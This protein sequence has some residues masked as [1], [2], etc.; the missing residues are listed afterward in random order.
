MTLT[1]M[2]KSAATRMRGRG[3]VRHHLSKVDV[4][5]AAFAAKIRSTRVEEILKPT[6]I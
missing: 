1:N 2:K 4:V 5:L 6:R 3:A